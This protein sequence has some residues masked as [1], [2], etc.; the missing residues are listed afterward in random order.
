MAE[1]PSSLQAFNGFAGENMLETSDSEPGIE[2]SIQPGFE[3]LLDR[4]LHQLITGDFQSRWETMKRISNV[5]VAAIPVLVDL[6]QELLQEDADWQ[7]LWFVAR[8]L[9]SL[10]D[11]TAVDALINLL[12]STDNSEVATVAATALAQQGYA[13]I[14]PL[15]QL[16]EEPNLRLFAVQALSQIHHAAVVSPLLSIAQ[17]E[18]SA[19]RA[20]AIE[21]LSRFYDPLIPPVLLSALTDRVAIV[22]QAAVTALG[23]Q[24]AQC[25]DQQALIYQ[26][27]PLLKDLNLEVCRHTAIAFGRIGTDAAVAALAELLQTP[28]TPLLLQLEVVRALARIESITAIEQLQYFLFQPAP[29]SDAFLEVSQEIVMLL[30]RVS[31]AEAK[32]AALPLLQT[33]LTTTHPLAQ[34]VQGK[35]AI[36]FSL[37]QLGQVAALDTLIQLLADP[38]KSVQLHAIAALKRL[39][40]DLAYQKLQTL[41]QR[42]DLTEDLSQG[43]AIA[44][45]EWQG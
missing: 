22:R 36:T 20:A 40:P 39:A 19:V 24:S 26:L 25:L 33:L 1:I 30:G 14:S 4:L 37:G 34:Q 8:I 27:R 15:A 29:T 43:I 11:A 12:R 42:P 18:S 35:Q 44:L 31:S 21:A 16:L 9:G 5:G 3:S 45:Q 17:D 7:I 13:A 10:E 23:F 41:A 2:P 28:H 6:V 32:Q 38:A